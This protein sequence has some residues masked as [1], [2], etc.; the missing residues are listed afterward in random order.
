MVV[1]GEAGD[2]LGV[3]EEGAVNFDHEPSVIEEESNVELNE[4]RDDPDEPNAHKVSTKMF[5]LISKNMLAAF[6]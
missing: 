3:N 6:I 4:Q 2:Q 1:V 5:R